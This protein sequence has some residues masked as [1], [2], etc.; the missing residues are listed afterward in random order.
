[1]QFSIIFLFLSSSDEISPFLN[2]PSM[3][4]IFFHLFLGTRQFLFGTTAMLEVAHIHIKC[5]VQC[6]TILYS[7]AL[8][9]V[10]VFINFFILFCIRLSTFCG[11]RMEKRRLFN[12][13]L[14]VFSPSG[15][16]ADLKE[17]MKGPLLLVERCIMR[18]LLFSINC[19]SVSTRLAIL[20][21]ISF[22]QSYLD[23]IVPHN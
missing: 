19:Y 11:N 2:F 5:T 13:R 14:I 16:P 18:L 22:H 1:M 6:Y 9:Y 10:F 15:L 4:S 3:L 20:C 7:I 23:H 12:Y 8:C 17:K 21:L